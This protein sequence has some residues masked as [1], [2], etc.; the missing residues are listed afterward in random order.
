MNH[1]SMSYDLTDASSVA[2]WAWTSSR[3]ASNIRNL[4]NEEPPARP[5]HPA[6]R[7]RD[8]VG[9]YAHQFVPDLHRF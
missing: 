1:L 9:R 4:F 2:A 3:L 5:P 8:L 7:L 6:R